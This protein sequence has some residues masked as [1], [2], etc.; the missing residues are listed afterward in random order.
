MK[1]SS[2]RLTLLVA[3]SLTF[4]VAFGAMVV[5]GNPGNAELFDPRTGPSTPAA[6]VQFPRNPATTS[7]VPSAVGRVRGRVVDV[8]GHPVANARVFA[9][10]ADEAA[11]VEIL[12]REL[13]ARR[14]ARAGVVELDAERVKRGR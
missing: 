4:L 5:M 11:S 6:D 7:T 3:T 9:L 8:Q 14:E 1:S 13:Q 10:G 12:S 2:P